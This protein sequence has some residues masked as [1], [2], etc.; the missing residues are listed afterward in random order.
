MGD[1]RRISSRWFTDH[2][3]CGPPLPV[4]WGKIMGTKDVKPLRGLLVRMIDRCRQLR[5]HRGEAPASQSPGGLP[6]SLLGQALNAVSEGSVITDKAQNIVYANAAFTAVTGY[7]EHEVLGRNCRFLQG[8]GSNPQTVQALSLSLSRGKS[9]RGEL[10]NYRKDGTPFWNA[11]TVS[12]IKDATGALSHFVSVQRDITAQKAQQARLRFLAMHDPVTGLPNRTALDQHLG[13]NKERSS[14]HQLTAVGIIDL[15]DFKIINDTY[16]HETGDLLLHEFALRL[17]EQ[18]RDTDFLARLGGDEFVVVIEELKK[19]TVAE[20]LGTVLKRLHQ[21][22]ETDFVLGENTIATV[23][24][25]MGLS[26][27]SH[28]DESEQT[29]LR[30]A[31]EALYHLK[32]SKTERGNWWH[33]DEPHHGDDISPHIHTPAEDHT[34]APRPQAP[35]APAE[36]TAQ[37]YRQRL[38]DGGLRMFF[39]PVID[40]RTGSVHLLEALAR[41]AL[42]D[43]TILLPGAFMPLLPGQDIDR[44]FRTG[45]YQVLQQLSEWDAQGLSVSVSI[46]LAPSTLLNP[47]CTEWVR[48]ALDQHNIAPG[49]LCL[50]LLET[51]PAKDDIQRRTFDELH[52]LGVRMVLDDLGSGYSSLRRLTAF[53]FSTVKIDRHLTSQFRTSPITAM[54]FLATLVQMGRD[55]GWDVVAEGLENAAIT[56]AATIL[57]IPYGQGYHL[58]RPMEAAAIPGWARDLRPSPREKP[59]QTMLGALAYHWQFARLGSPHPGTLGECPLTSFLNNVRTMDDAAIGWHQEQHAGLANHPDC[60]TKLTQ[61]LTQKSTENHHTNADDEIQGPGASTYLAQGLPQFLAFAFDA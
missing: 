41:L 11:L 26:L 30:R 2:S 52:G 33:L 42:A 24:M 21:A 7:S 53:A 10:L 28:A 8:P 15:D 27:H 40:L 61:W 47:R 12:P 23:S 35:P 37:A 20:Q 58:A 5:P 46:N 50:E 60:A 6:E 32:N 18:L 54:T 43:G 4:L 38:L 34:R 3:Q 39:Q 22:V 9:F 19:E 29:T 55:M 1:T 49:R 36:A 44:M 48:S 59:I 56:E 17:Q 31:D 25:S 45:L 16:G 13:K 14:P 57:G 51:L